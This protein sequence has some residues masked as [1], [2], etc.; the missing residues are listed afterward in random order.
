MALMGS[1]PFVYSA[2]LLF[3]WDRDLGY[4]KNNV[5]YWVSWT[6]FPAFGVLELVYCFIRLVR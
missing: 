3:I 4:R 1:V 5:A 2:F 6:V